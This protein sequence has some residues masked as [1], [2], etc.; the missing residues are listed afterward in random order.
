[1]NIY[2]KCTNFQT[3][4]K[5]SKKV[6]SLPDFLF[7]T[8]LSHLFG[9]LLHRNKTEIRIIFYSFIKE[10]I[11]TTKISVIALFFRMKLRTF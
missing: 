1:M 5:V 8:H 10:Y 7:V 9:P 3:T 2:E 4:M 11:A 6:Q